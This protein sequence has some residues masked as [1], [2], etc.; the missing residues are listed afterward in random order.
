VIAWVSVSGIAA[1]TLQGSMRWE[2]ALPFGMGAIIAM[3][4]GQRIVGKLKAESLR[5]AF[6][7]ISALVALLMLAKAVGW[8]L[9]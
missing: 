2:V 3:L 1:A 8:S 4:A 7:L 9:L 6:A 5:Q